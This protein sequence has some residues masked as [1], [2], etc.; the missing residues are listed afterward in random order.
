MDD[1]SHRETGRVGFLGATYGVCLRT[2]HLRRLEG[3]PQILNTQGP[4]YEPGR[5]Y[6]AFKQL[7]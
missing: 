2:A 7:E 6:L 3:W 1:L 5:T 4:V